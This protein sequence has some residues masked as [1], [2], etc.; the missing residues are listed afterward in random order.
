L[1][2]GVLSGVFLGVLLLQ[3]VLS[4][5][6]QQILSVLVQFQINNLDIGR[7]DRHIDIL[8]VGL[9]SGQ[10]LDKDRVLLSVNLSDLS[11]VALESTAHDHNFIILTDRHGSD[12]VL[13][14]QF[15]GQ[16]SSHQLSSEM[17]RS[18]ENCLSALSSG[19]GDVL[20]SL[21]IGY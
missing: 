10:F 20:V 8:T 7:M 13:G 15:S 17:G 16:M 12:I 1:H 9:I 14:L 19:A 4:L 21:H 2:G 6:L 5:S 18:S 3:D 11:L